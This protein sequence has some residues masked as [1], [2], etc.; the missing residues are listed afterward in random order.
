MQVSEGKIWKIRKLFHRLLHKSG[1]KTVQ[2]FIFTFIHESTG[3]IYLRNTLID[4]QFAVAG[5]FK[6]FLLEVG[7]KTVF[8]SNHQFK[9]SIFT[10]R[11]KR[12]TATIKKRKRNFSVGIFQRFSFHRFSEDWVAQ[13]VCQQIDGQ[14]THFSLHE[15]TQEKIDLEKCYHLW[16][17]KIHKIG[18][19]RWISPRL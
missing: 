11:N 13:N 19:H 3:R 18:C 15:H 8:N 16:L 6:G 7:T 4:F 2:F 5:H 14:Q 12:S 9:S 1:F 17:R 10:M